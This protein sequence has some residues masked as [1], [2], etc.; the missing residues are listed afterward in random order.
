MKS[1][2][3]NPG[4]HMQEDEVERYC[5]RQMSEAESAGFE[6]HLLTCEE[7]RN[8]VLEID[9][10]L[11]AMYNAGTEIRNAS[12]RPLVW[13]WTMAVASALALV[14]VAIFLIQPA[15]SP[16]FQEARLYAMRGAALGPKVS[17]Q[18]PLVLVPDLTGL[19]EY[20]SY[21]LQLVDAV[22]KQVAA[23]QVSASNPSMKVNR[24]PSGV[25]FVRLLSP[26]GQLLRE[27]GL[28]SVR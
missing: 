20:S 5:M 17:A 14:L 15:Q 2:V 25:Y 28:E 23:G 16:E 24:V 19:P 13:S 6:E 9:H 1:L 3:I 22:G 21:G 10:Y 11:G 12:R 26:E 27:Y 8:R 18:S 7:C 4:R